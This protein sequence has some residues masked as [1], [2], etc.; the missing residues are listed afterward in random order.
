MRILQHC[1]RPGLLLT[2]AGALIIATVGASALD[3]A[4]QARRAFPED[5]VPGPPPPF[6][7]MGPREAALKPGTVAP[8]LALADFR[9][10]RRVSLDDYRG[11]RPVVLLF[12]I[13]AS[14]IFR[15]QL[16]PVRG[17][18]EQYKGRVAFL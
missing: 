1:P 15:G 14:D 6:L 3:Q 4:R 5:A 11:D 2:L 7:L 8:P 13:L 16:A 9:T 12:G 17:L 18:H 10:G